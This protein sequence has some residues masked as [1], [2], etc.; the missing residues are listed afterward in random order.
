MRIRIRAAGYLI[1][2]ILSMASLVAA[3][4]DLRLVEAIERQDREAVRTLLEQEVDVNTSQPDGATALHWA[5]HWNDL[6]TV[7]H[8]VRAGAHVNAMNELGVV[9][10]SLACAN[11]DS[12]MLV[13]RLVRAGADPNAA[14][15]SGETVLM[16]AARTGNL[17]AV[18]VLLAH[19]AD[20]N[21]NTHWR[22]QTAL[23]WAVAEGHADIMA[24]L[25]AHGAD[26]HARSN[27]GGTPLLLAARAGRVDAARLLLAA[28]A[29][30]NAVEP[31][32]MPGDGVDVNVTLPTGN[33]PLL[34]ASASMVA[35][36]G[37]EYRLAVK[38]SG[39]EALAMFLLE[40]GADP[41]KTDSI[42]TTPLH[43]AVRTGKLKL[44]QALL[45]HG[46]D[47]NARLVKAPAAVSSGT[48]PSTGDTSARH[49]SGWR[50][51]PESPI[52]T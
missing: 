40:A 48:I 49:R 34:V 45:A 43:A 8:L 37:F 7:D 22:G 24:V 32:V 39:H 18:N 21:A 3:N 23:M 1:A 50:R 52:S 12:A 6:D 19:G 27:R 29:D 17:S 5:A 47:P 36:S 51:Q 11:L 10:L 41:T 13:E 28:G 38:P 31:L 30:V 15:P 25:I 35:T 2:P 9:P 14:L 20:M 44:V 33:S 42:G 16:T 26:V 46:A 4:S